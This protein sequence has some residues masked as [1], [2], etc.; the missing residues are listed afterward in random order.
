MLSISVFGFVN[1]LFNR[2]PPSEPAFEA[3]PI[4]DTA[5]WI[6]WGSFLTLLIGFP[7]AQAVAP[8]IVKMP[9]WN[10]D[11]KSAM[12]CPLNVPFQGVKVHSCPYSI[13]QKS[14]FLIANFMTVCM[15]VAGVIATQ[16]ALLQPYPRLEHFAWT[17]ALPVG[18]ISMFFH[19]IILWEKLHNGKQVCRTASGFTPCIAAQVIFLWLYGAWIFSVSASPVAT[20]LLGS[21]LVVS[22][23][24]V[25]ACVVVTNVFR[26]AFLAAA[27]F[28]IDDFEAM[29][30]VPQGTAKSAEPEEL[31]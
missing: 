26:F 31:M 6:W 7:L 8:S 14:R 4:L 22:G 19:T 30:F 1:K 5:N 2:P 15:V 25:L 11:L 12:A 13:F 17:V 9:E 3:D 18:A 10:L 23:Y 27:K 21:I 28:D 16:T 20:T 29:W 24:A